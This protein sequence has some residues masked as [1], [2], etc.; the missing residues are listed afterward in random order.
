MR[1]GIT[2]TFLLLFSSL[3]SGCMSE[4]GSIFPDPGEIVDEDPMERD[5]ENSSEIVGLNPPQLIPVDYRVASFH[6]APDGYTYAA[7]GGIMVR[8]IN[9]GDAIEEITRFN[10]TIRSIHMTING[11]FFVSTDSSVWNDTTPNRIYRSQDGGNNW[12]VVKTIIGGGCAI[13]WSIASDDQGRLYVGEYGPTGIN[14]SKRVWKSIDQGDTWEVIFTADNVEGVH[15]HRVAIDPYTNDVWI[16][17]GD[18]FEGIYRSTDEGLNFHL[19]RISQPTSVL[20]TEESIYWGEDNWSGTITIF[21]R[22]SSNFST[23]FRA[24]DAGTNYGG[25]I[26]DMARGQSGMI[27]APMVK[28]SYHTHPPTLW[29]GEGTSWNLTQVIQTEVGKSGGYFQISQPDKWGNMYVF[30]FKIVESEM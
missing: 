21:D 4:E 20:F 14:Q 3:I 10:Q 18:E 6:T 22:N 13:H 23:A 9:E 30:G 5:D 8:I 1:W 26:Y 24:Y 28:Y 7:M 29:R 17:Q 15:I 27:Y 16:T 2:I 19:M 11:T 25:P 12:D